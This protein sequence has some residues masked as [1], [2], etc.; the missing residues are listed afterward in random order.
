MASGHLRGRTLAALL[1][2]LFS[3][4]CVALGWPG[5]AQAS[6][7]LILRI[8]PYLTATEI[9]TRFAP[10]ASYLSAQLGRKVEIRISPSYQE[11]VAKVGENDFDIAYLGPASYVTLTRTFGKERALLA[12]LEVHGRPFFHGVIICRAT[13]PFT[14]LADLKGRRFAFGDQLSTMSHYVPRYLLRQAGVS[15]ADLQSHRFL[16]T[17]HN[18]ALAVL[19]GYADAGAVKEEVYEQYKERGLRLLAKS[20]P[21]PEH[22]FVMRSSLSAPL[23]NQTRALLLTLKDRPEG[24]A[25]LTA[26]KKTVTGLAPVRDQ[27]YDILRQILSTVPDTTS[28]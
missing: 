24:K 19:A 8:H 11:H 22:L 2:S 28:P 9:H 27:D 10:L 25:V 7:P 26:I 4:A 17:H 5:K 14:R 6:G 15:L 20:P 23:V 21:I 12:R 13:A 3:V 18:V 1:F 16:G